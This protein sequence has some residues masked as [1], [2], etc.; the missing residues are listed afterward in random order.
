MWFG[1]YYT[2]PLVF[3]Y[4]GIKGWFD[5]VTWPRLALA[6]AMVGVLVW[7]APNT[8]IYTVAQFMEWSHGRFQAARSAPLSPTAMG[9]IVSG[10]GSSV[11][12]LVGGMVWSVAFGTL[13]IWLPARLRRGKAQPA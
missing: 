11:I 13:L 6:M 7:F 4:A 8:I 9:K 1:V 3:I 12:T 2:M 10:L 5:G